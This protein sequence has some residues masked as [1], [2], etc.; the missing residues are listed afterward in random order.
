MSAIP[1]V[2]AAFGRLLRRA[3]DPDAYVPGQHRSP[4]FGEPDDFDAYEETNENLPNE[5]LPV[6]T[7]Q[8]RQLQIRE[9][10]E[11]TSTAKL[12]PPLSET[13]LIQ[14]LVWISLPFA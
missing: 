5:N 8:E 4:L 6:Y 7:P 12:A 2:S 14:K 11:A 1:P 9:Q 10:I 3:L 13:Q